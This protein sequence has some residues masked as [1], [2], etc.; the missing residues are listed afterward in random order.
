MDPKLLTTLRAEVLREVRGPSHGERSFAYF[1]QIP[2][3]SFKGELSHLYPA[4]GHSIIL[5]QILAFN[6]KLCEF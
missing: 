1:L 3:N 2:R 5:A 4:G 6:Q